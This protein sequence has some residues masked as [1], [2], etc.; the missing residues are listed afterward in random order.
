V[1]VF[2]SFPEQAEAKRLLRAAVADEGPAHAYL[3][4]G[5][6]GVGK[7]A[8][9]IAFAGELIGDRGRVERGAHPDVYLIEPVGDQ[10]RIDDIRE[11]RRDLHM[12]PFEADRRVYLLHSAETMNEDA[13]DALLKDLEEPP[14]YAVIVLVADD[15]GPLPD[16]IRSRCQLVPFMRLSERAIRT[17]IDARAPGLSPNEAAS[18][19]RLAAGRLDRVTRLLDPEST[20]R[21]DTLLQVARS[22]Y[23]DPEFEPGAAAQRLLDGARERAAEAKVKA[24]EDLET[25]D[26]TAREA[27]QRVRRAARGAERDELL[28]SLEELAS[29]YRDLV[30]V[31]VGAESAVV[32]ADRLDLLTEDGKT[33]RLAGAERAAEL[34]RETW[35][36][37]EEFNLSPPLALEAL[38][39]K[40]RRELGAYVPSLT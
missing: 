37:F 19:A 36:A 33:E 27:E 12:R 18:L 7:R 34:T 23:T 5:P 20:R 4:H 29:W 40:L 39:V 6:S 14:P 2:E 22:V 15:L 31:A 38:F 35:R 30:V 28:A 11:L 3:F 21:R 13:A 9:A 26:L 8:A 32:H 10:I 1:S 24:E 16:T 17:E 25:L